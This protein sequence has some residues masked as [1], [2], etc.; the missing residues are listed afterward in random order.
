M[1]THSSTL[2]WKIPWTEEYCGLQSMGSQRVGHDWVISLSNFQYKFCLYPY[3][4]MHTHTHILYKHFCCCSVA[5]S[6][7]ALC[8]PT[9]CS[10]PSSSVHGISQVRI[11]EWV[12][13]FSPR[14]SIRPRD[15]IHVSCN[16][17]RIFTAEL[18]GKSSYISIYLCKY[19]CIWMGI[20]TYNWQWFILSIIFK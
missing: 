8:D 11:Q 10:P 18:P 4:C 14:E 13:I 3:I 7:Q 12:A 1:A 17:R 9:D 20:H 19:T 15:Q 2:A 6:C 5:K 16:G